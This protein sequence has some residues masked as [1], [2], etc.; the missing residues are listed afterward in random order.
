VDNILAFSAGKDVQVSEK[1]VVKGKKR[2]FLET[3]ELQIGACRGVVWAIPQFQRLCSRPH[4]Y[5]GVNPMCPPR[6]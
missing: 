2:K 5:V 3:V 4:V 6:P 1:S